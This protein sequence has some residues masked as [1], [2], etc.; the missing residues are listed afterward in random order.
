MNRT[1]ESLR[2]IYTCTGLIITG[3]CGALALAQYSLEGSFLG[4]SGSSAVLNL[5]ALLAGCALT[6]KGTEAMVRR[7][8]RKLDSGL[9][10]HM[11]YRICRWVVRTVF[12]VVVFIIC[13]ALDTWTG[14]RY[15]ESSPSLTD[16]SIRSGDDVWDVNPRH[17][18]E[19][20]RR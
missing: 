11:S 1:N 6:W 3:G 7:Q 8:L 16:T 13:V 17:Y 9:E 18:H 19:D 15:S 2:R 20:E 5:G 14:R 4:V 10:A 12:K